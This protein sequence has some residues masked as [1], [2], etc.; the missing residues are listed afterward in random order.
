[1]CLDNRHISNPLFGGVGRDMDDT[2]PS[3]K[4]RNCLF[5]PL[6]SRCMG[7]RVVRPLRVARCRGQG[8]GPCPSVKKSVSS[9]SRLYKTGYLSGGSMRF[10][11]RMDCGVDLAGGKGDQS[12]C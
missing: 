5:P 1:M 8:V 6:H 4:T 11:R 7:S 3:R 2:E 12:S 9:M 10:H